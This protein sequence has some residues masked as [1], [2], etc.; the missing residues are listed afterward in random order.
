ML[1]REIR[2][3]LK[4]W[5]SNS[6]MATDSEV[7]ASHFLTATNSIEF[8][9]VARFIFADDIDWVFQ[10]RFVTPRSLFKI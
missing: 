9:R 1:L 4:K 7:L 2:D 5:V 10:L 8:F 6:L 3:S